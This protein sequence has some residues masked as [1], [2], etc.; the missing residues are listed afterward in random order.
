MFAYSA[1]YG[2]IP[3]AISLDL[4]AH[5]SNSKIMEEMTSEGFWIDVGAHPAFGEERPTYRKLPI[6]KSTPFGDGATRIDLILLNRIA[7]EAISDFQ[8]M[9]DR[10]L[11]GH[12]PLK[13]CLL[14][15]SP[16][17]RD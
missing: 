13:I 8:P 5:V 12:L 1:Y 16:S 15:T 10:N 11:P 6:N 4:N 2:D 3:V 9:Y 7:W 14:Y 17:P